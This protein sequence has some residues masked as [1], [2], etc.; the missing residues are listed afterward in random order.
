[1]EDHEFDKLLDD[2]RLTYRVP[3]QPRADVMWRGIEARAFGAA[4]PSLWATWRMAGL[5]AAASL[6]IGVFAGRWSARLTPAAPAAPVALT[7]APPLIATVAKP[8]QQ[9]TEDV[10]GRAAVLIT[11]VRSSDVRTAAQLSAQA[12]RLLGSTRLLLDSPA[13]T[14]PRLRALLFDLEITLAQIARMQPSRG[15]TELT[16]INDAVAE[17]DIVPRIRSAVVDLSADGY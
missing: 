4:R 11:A 14:D 7:T 16:L 12:T 9:A 1:M 15:A 17:R 3:P 5:A 6:V 8:Y 2:A 13:A 10:L